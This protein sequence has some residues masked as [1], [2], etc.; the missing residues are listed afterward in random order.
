M[1]HSKSSVNNNSAHSSLWAHHLLKRNLHPSLP[2]PGHCSNS[3]ESDRWDVSP[4]LNL[5]HCTQSSV[6]SV[7]NIDSWINLT[8]SIY[9]LLFLMCLHRKN[10][11]TN[12]EWRKSTLKYTWV[13]H[14]L[15][16]TISGARDKRFLFDPI[17]S[18]WIY[19]LHKLTST[20]HPIEQSPTNEN[21]THHGG[22]H[23]AQRTSHLSAG[24]TFVSLLAL[25]HKTYE[26][27][28]PQNLQS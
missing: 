4:P 11:F 27:H 15:V 6:G 20:W 28:E 8:F 19:R 24:F 26:S 14:T 13:G 21:S 22:L 12:A 23:H 10:K 9:M 17:Q 7:E 5:V 3:D 1:W 2:S 18:A 25:F 16:N